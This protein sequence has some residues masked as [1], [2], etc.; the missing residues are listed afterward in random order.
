MVIMV[1]LRNECKAAIWGFKGGLKSRRGSHIRP[2]AY[3]A[4]EMVTE[5]VRERLDRLRNERDDRLADR[6]LV[7]GMDCAARLAELAWALGRHLLLLQAE[8]HLRT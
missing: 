4:Q 3:S 7:I 2:I 8:P 6:L 5:A 1:I